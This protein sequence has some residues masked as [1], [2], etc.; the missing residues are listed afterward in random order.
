MVRRP[1]R[2]RRQWWTWTPS[3]TVLLVLAAVAGAGLADRPAMRYTSDTELSSTG[4]T[5]AGADEFDGPE[6]SAPDPRYWVYDTGAGGWGNDEE[7]AYT[8]SRDNVRLDGAGRLLIQARRDG[9]G[10]TSARLVSRKRVEVRYGLLEARI[11][12]PEGQG[13]HSAFWL[14]GVDVWKVGWPESGEI[15]IIEIVNS[16]VNYHNAIHGPMSSDSDKAWK[17]SADGNAGVNL[18]DDYHV[19]QVYREP[20]TVKI[21]LDG[22]VVGSYS[23]SSAPAGADWVFDAPMYVVL[24]VAVG[25]QW[26]GP[27][28][29][30]TQFPA[31][32]RVDW[33]RYWV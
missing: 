31:T 15:D 8:K 7:Q 22:H 29:P 26:P 2:R 12:M 13:I 21:G 10:F 18:S 20:G 11:R 17:Q 4:M 1:D 30:K 24:N 32:M 3:L 28:G 14:L 5:L 27:V 9:D 16:S 19:F 25:G 23:R 6:G 33:V